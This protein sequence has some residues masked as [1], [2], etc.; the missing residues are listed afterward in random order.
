MMATAPTMP[1]TKAK[2]PPRAITFAEWKREGEDLFG[3]DRSKW[4]VVCPAC[5]HV[6]M[7]GEWETAGAVNA[8]G[9]SCIGRY[10][11]CVKVRVRDAFGRGPGPCNYAG[12]GLIGLSTLKV[13]E[14]NG[15]EIGRFFEFYR[16]PVPA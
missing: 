2:S 9:F 15:E 6:A 16:E 8:A 5:G 1:A 7:L 13:C 10:L 12:G 3:P 11:D 14:D 4:K